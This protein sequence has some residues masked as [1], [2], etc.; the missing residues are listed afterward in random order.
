MK[1][2]W[3]LVGL[4]LMII[5]AIVFIQGILDV[6]GTKQGTTVLSTL[7]PN[8]WW[9]IVMILAGLAMFL[10]QRKKVLA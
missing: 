10:T 6:T 3:Y 9:G 2:I 8:F 7:Y 4:I 5:G 1:S